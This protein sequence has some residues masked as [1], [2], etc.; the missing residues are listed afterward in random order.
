MTRNL[1]I[2]PNDRKSTKYPSN[3]H[4]IGPEVPSVSQHG[5]GETGQERIGD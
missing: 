5:E 1:E 3:M 4:K 2:V